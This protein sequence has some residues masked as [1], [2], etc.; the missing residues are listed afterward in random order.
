MGNGGEK[1]GINA[2]SGVGSVF[3][4]LSTVSLDAKGRLAI[5]SRYRDRLAESGQQD[6]VLTINP[7]DRCL[8]LYPLPEW[9][10]IEVK[11]AALPEFENRQTRRTKQMLR[12][13]AVDLEV[14]AQGR[15]LLPQK[16]RE[17]A[18][19]ARHVAVVGQGNK[20]E[21]WDEDAWNRQRDEWLEEVDENA[22]EPSEA[23][24]RLAL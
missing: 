5:P 12:G 17:F 3:R 4:G 15:V 22:L 16:H 14:D 13:Y 6:L 8:W 24:R 21:L 11:L 7:L 9:E 1:W 20:F 23:L 2:P 18:G 19:L 10:L